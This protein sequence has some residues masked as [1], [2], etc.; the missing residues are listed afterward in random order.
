MLASGDS[1]FYH[2]CLK[3]RPIHLE[4]VAHIVWSW[5]QLLYQLCGLVK[6]VDASLARPKVLSSTSATG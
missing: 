4:F 6:S 3:N 5:D 2:A 1:L